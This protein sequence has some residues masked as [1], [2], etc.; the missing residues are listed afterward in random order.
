M[1]RSGSRRRHDY[2][3]L[4]G[5]ARVDGPD[6]AEVGGPVAPA[7]GIEGLD[8]LRLLARHQVG[9]AQTQLGVLRSV[10]QPAFADT[11][12]HQRKA[13]GEAAHRC[14]GE[15]EVEQLNAVLGPFCRKLELLW[16]DAPLLGQ[17]LLGELALQLAMPL[18]LGSRAEH[19]F[20]EALV[21]HPL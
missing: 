17:R 12:L 3:A 4:L 10:R 9:D 20:R 14:V 16:V 11:L 5:V 19:A 15:A 21:N 13:P 18:R 2:S 1:S 6:A 7:D 8:R